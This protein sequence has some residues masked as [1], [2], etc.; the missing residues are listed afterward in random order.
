MTNIQ[1]SGLRIG[2]AGSRFA[3]LAAISLGLAACG[4][5]GEGGDGGGSG[6]GTGEPTFPPGGSEDA[7][8]SVGS[9]VDT[10]SI[11]DSALTIISLT[12]NGDAATGTAA[13]DHDGNAVS[14]GSILD[15]TFESNRTRIALASGGD[16]LF[17]MKRTPSF[18]GCSAS[19]IRTQTQS[20]DLASLAPRLIHQLCQALGL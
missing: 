12:Q 6:G 5:G 3:F 9:F 17:S 4:A 8:T 15:G 1:R 18:C 13:F 16:A 10:V 2:K 7:G 14:G 19:K 11:D 20:T